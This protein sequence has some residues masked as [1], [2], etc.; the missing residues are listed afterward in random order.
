[1]VIMVVSKVTVNNNGGSALME[2]TKKNV[3]SMRFGGFV[4]SLRRALERG[5]RT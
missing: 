5:S 4:S 2:T 1:M 3:C